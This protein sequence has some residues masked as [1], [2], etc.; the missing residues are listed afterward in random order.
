MVYSFFT[1]MENGDRGFE[2]NSRNVC[3]PLSV[4]FS[5]LCLSLYVNVLRQAY[6]TSKQ[7]KQMF[8][9]KI[10]VPRRNKEALGCFTISRHTH[11]CTEY[12]SLYIQIY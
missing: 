8:E 10:H 9:N 11:K 2:Y 5:G 4:S 1:R 3:R 12:N 6:I 7:S